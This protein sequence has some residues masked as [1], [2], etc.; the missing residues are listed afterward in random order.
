[1]A[2]LSI[3]FTG[4]HAYAQ[5]NQPLKPYV[6]MILD[7]SGSMDVATGSGPTSCGTADLRFNHATCAINK[8]VNS[9][10]DMVFALGRFRETTNGTFATSCDA[11]LDLDGNVGV[12]LPTPTGGDQ[13]ST[14]GAYCGDCDESVGLGN[15]C[16]QNSQCFPYTNAG[17]CINGRCAA[18]YG[19]C[20]AADRELE[21][22]SPLIDGN[23]A[24]AATYT[25]GI[26]NSCSIAPGGQPELWGVS[27]YTF[28][29]LAAVLNGAKRYWSGA[30]ATDSTVIWPS[31]TPGF[32][33]IA[34]DPTATS[35]L[36]QGCDSSPGCT[37]NCCASQCRPYI[38]IL[39]TDG[40]ETC[41]TFSNTTSAAASLLSTDLG[42]RRYRIET[43]PIG[44]GI[45]PGDAQIEAI[46]QAGG[47]PNLAGN[48][49]Y[50]ASDE[51]SLQL[52]ISN[53]LDDAIK[54]EVCNNLDD[55]CDTIV[56]EGFTKG[57]ACTNNRLGKCLLTGATQ[58]RADGA[59]TQCSAGR[60]STP[61]CTAMNE[62]AA[63]TVVNAANATVNGTCQS[64]VC[65][66]TAAPDEIALG[67]NNIDDDCDGRI[68]EGV[69]GCVCSPSTEVCGGGDNDC[70]GLV[71]EGTALPCGTGT[72]VGVRPCVGGVQG[73]CNAPTP[74]PAEICNGLDD[75]CDGIIDGFQQSCS[76]MTCPGGG[77]TGG[78]AGQRT[79]VGGS[80]AG[81]RCDTFPAFD[82]RNNP[83]GNPASACE[84]LGAQCVCNPGNRTCPSNGG[85]T[86]T[87]CV[88]EI[89]PG[90]EVCN[91][92]DDDCDGLVDEAPPVTC[93]TDANCPA[94]TPECDNPTSM[95]NMGSCQPADCS[96]NSCGGNLVCVNGVQTCTLVTGVDTTCN[97]VDEDCDMMVDEGWLCTDPDGLDNIAGNADDCPCTGAG[98]CNSHE[99]C[100]NGSVLCQGD[101]VG[102]E[103]CNCLDDNCNGQVDEG[104]LCGTGATCTNCQCAF[105]CIPGEFACPMGKSCIGGFC[106]ADPCFNFT[107]PDVA[108][109]KQICR[110][111][112]M[113]PSD[114]E[115]VSACAPGVHN[116]AA[117]N[118]CYLPTG[119]CRPDTC[120][121]FPER[122]AANE[123]CINGACIGNPCDGVTCA[124]GESCVA[125]QCYG[126]CA[127]V[128]CPPGER[129]R[130]GACEADPCDPPCP[131][132]Q[133]CQQDDSGCIANP[134]EFVVCPGGQWC[135]PYN[136]G[137]CEDDP[138]Q[139]FDVKC[140]EG[141][142]CF[143]GTCFDAADFLPD[144]GVET[145]VTTGGG[146]GCSTSG[147]AGGSLLLGIGLLLVVGRRRRSETP[148]ADV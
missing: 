8:I 84:A 122:C 67:C 141:E 60:V 29:P 62:N 146:G 102:Q 22:L 135:N 144:A 129:C 26:C 109:D 68:D 1:M 52:A 63:C 101:P 7:T 4:S 33:P 44:F 88:Q 131:G 107:C 126:S 48:E 10:G 77:C 13:C 18:G 108:G 28:T 42:G 45:N 103:S 116:C 140:A 37:S 21:I 11:N 130:L 128:N 86:F 127:D 3:V 95:P 38:T 136:G 111:K 121:T 61:T 41:T 115:C 75:T 106:L 16:T 133:F 9:Y 137:A 53:I 94:M 14:Q 148:D 17:S 36:P 105:Q 90:V 139:V 120:E 24:A 112:A 145:H 132:G 55:D 85:G 59:G 40:A 73:A 81:L 12:T 30:Q 79:C 65:E 39:L 134:C 23:N 56:D 114:K 2:T 78:V 83:G 123:N 80:R 19:N 66:P 74:L 49:G 119:E 31:N 104:A 15:A 25:D 125:G 20:T 72:C 97:G 100:E 69:T 93:T 147:D 87:A 50:Y 46:A 143:G 142:K 34:N 92:L 57:T 89:E 32:A 110:P 64:S 99:S 43:K 82:P 27:P 70:D 113:N 117:P 118:I 96:L 6:V 98:Q 47:E 124:T 138:C 58:C 71:D 5:A 76:N 51:A 54:T 35:F 91:N